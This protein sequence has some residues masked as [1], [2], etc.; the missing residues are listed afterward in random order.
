MHA[1]EMMNK[2]PVV[3]NNNKPEGATTTNGA[4]TDGQHAPDKAEQRQLWFLCR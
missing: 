1:A 3:N 4:T 2:A